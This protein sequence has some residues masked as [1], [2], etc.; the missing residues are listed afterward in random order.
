MESSEGLQMGSTPRLTQKDDQSCHE[1]SAEEYR[2]RD[3]REPNVAW[4]A[5]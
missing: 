3:T 4:I 2:W 5:Q 1:A